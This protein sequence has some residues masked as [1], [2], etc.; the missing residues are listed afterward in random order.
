MD[1]ISETMLRCSTIGSNFTKDMAE[2]R[3]LAV[4]M[5]LNGCTGSQ[6]GLVLLVDS[7]GGGHT[8]LVD[9]L[10]FFRRNSM[11]T[12]ATVAVGDCLSA[13]VPV[14]ASGW[15]D[16]RVAL[17]GARF[18]VHPMQ[19]EM[20]FS[21]SFLTCHERILEETKVCWSRQEAYIAMLAKLTGQDPFFWHT[22]IFGPD[23]DHPDGEHATCFGAEEAL[24]WGVVDT[25]CEDMDEA[26]YRLRKMWTE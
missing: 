13:A 14:C 10:D 24:E 1:K 5:E 7:V 3:R 9:G 4:E 12:C 8:P 21:G 16:Y 15:K 17:A 25:I 6:H 22:K 23:V 18:M 11:V 26:M 20:S 19:I 2:A